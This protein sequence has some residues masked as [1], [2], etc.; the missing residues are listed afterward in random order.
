MP[1]VTNRREFF[2]LTASLTLFL[3]QGAYAEPPDDKTPARMDAYGDPL[4][5]GAIARLGTIRLR[6]GGQIGTVAFSPTRGILVS[7]GGDS[8]IKFWDSETG[9]EKA[10]LQ[11]HTN[12]VYSIAFSPD[13]KLL[14]SGSADENIMLW[15]LSQ[16]QPGRSISPALTLKGHSKPIRCVAFSPDGKLLASASEDA[17]VKLWDLTDWRMRRGANQPLHTFISHNEVQAYSVAF[18]PNGKNVALGS[19]DKTVKLWDVSSGKETATLRGHNHYVVAL[20][21]SPNGKTL[22]SGDLE[23][24]LKLWDM[25]QVGKKDIDA[26]I[27]SINAHKYWIFALA[28][29]RDGKK[30]ASGSS[31]GK[32]QIWDLNKWQPDARVPP[33]QTLATNY[34]LSSV[35]FSPDGKM[36]ASGGGDNVVKLWNGA[37]GKQIEVPKPQPGNEI[38]SK[39]SLQGAHAGEVRAVAFSPDGRT[40]ATGGN[41]ESTLRLWR[42]FESPSDTTTSKVINLS[43]H[44]E[45]FICLAFNP[46][47]KTLASGGAGGLV[48]IWDIPS[49]A[50]GTTLLAPV[51]GFESLAYSPD[52]RTLAAA[53]FDGPIR[54]WDLKSGKE[55]KPLLGPP[56]YSHAA[57]SPD[58][59]R[60]A[61]NGR[62]GIIKLWDVASGREWASVTHGEE[63]FNGMAFSPDGKILAAGNDEEEIVLWDIVTVQK[64]GIL[65][66]HHFAVRSLAFSPDGKTLASAGDD[67]VVKIW[68]LTKIRRGMLSAQLKSNPNVW[69][70]IN[71]QIAV[72]ASMV[73]DLEGHLN[74][75]TGVSFSP[76]GTILASSSRDTTAILWDIAKL[77]AKPDRTSPTLGADA[78]TS[79]WN[80]LAG[81]NAAK[82]YEAIWTLVSVPGQAVPFIRTHVRPVPLP[83]LKRLASLIADLD[84]NDFATRNQAI[85][86]LEKLQDLTAPFIREQ[87]KKQ[88]SLEVRRRL[89]QF[90]DKIEGPVTDPEQLRALRAVEVLEHIG[91]PEAREVLHALA[92]G[93]PEVRLTQ[94]AKASLRR[95][96]KRAS[97]SVGT[98]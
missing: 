89:E 74:S 5:P 80:D 61:A 37:T 98:K 1:F 25:N 34:S 95:L 53:S 21:F 41:Q 78:I 94:E 18:S 10:V 42:L 2:L 96:D 47:G 4:P 51:R 26:P 73:R 85:K 29:T 77:G 90:L 39:I 8:L 69:Y 79:C 46:D 16:W 52:G 88:M 72:Q 66:G 50:E 12:M 24:V 36:L 15:D 71:P 40:I 83:D 86:D 13:E 67:D 97:K 6:H 92:K 64:I 14:A 65:H 3:T 43:G 7:C 81:G 48:K 62:D 75:V 28:F 38:K 20:A 33:S 68:D 84:S 57:F 11:G 35:A 59:T 32:V 22:A 87:L 76:D 63:P 17:T 44:T 49:G 82:A 58:G 54:F 31:D 60:I 93:A 23:G 27:I 55:K 70:R 9:K 30:L 19:N 56:I 91:T 45:L